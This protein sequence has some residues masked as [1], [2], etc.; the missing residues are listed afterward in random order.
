MDPLTG[1][2]LADISGVNWYKPLP[3]LVILIVP[4]APLVDRVAVAVATES[5]FDSKGALYCPAVYPVPSLEIVSPV[6]RFNA[7]LLMAKFLLEKIP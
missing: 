3:S 4:I 7:F 6:V 1:V 2:K 5:G